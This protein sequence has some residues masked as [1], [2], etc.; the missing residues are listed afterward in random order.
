MTKKICFYLNYKLLPL[1][2]GRALVNLKLQY[3][4][5]IKCMSRATRFPVHR[6]V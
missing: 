1:P 4:N 5:I 3:R 6:F 2:F